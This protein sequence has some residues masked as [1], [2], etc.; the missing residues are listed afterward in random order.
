MKKVILALLAGVFIAA[1][2]VYATNDSIQSLHVNGTEVW[3][4]DEEGDVTAAGSITAPDIT[5]TDDVSVGGEFN[6]WSRT[7][8]QINAL[9]PTAAGRMVFCSDCTRS[10]VCISTGTGTG[11]WAIAVSTGVNT[12]K[13]IDCQ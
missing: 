8:A 4:I 6:M 2:Y 10:S 13:D 3:R 7:L 12:Y 1:G 9:T 5:A 11:A